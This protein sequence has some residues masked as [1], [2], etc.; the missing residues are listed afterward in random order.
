MSIALSKKITVAG[1]VRLLLWK[2]FTLQKRHY[3]QTFFDVF[4]PVI[5]FI[6]YALLYDY[7]YKSDGSSSDLYNQTFSRY[8]LNTIDQ[9]W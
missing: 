7:N 1:K 8:P 3:F 6:F 5:F 2:N 9:L 4:L